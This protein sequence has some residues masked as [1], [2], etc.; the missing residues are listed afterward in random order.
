METHKRIYNKL[1]DKVELASEK[2]ELSIASDIQKAIKALIT[3]EKEMNKAN[4]EILSALKVLEQAKKQSENTYQKYKVGIS[5][6][7]SINPF[8]V[9]R[10]AK[11]AAKELGINANAIKGFDILESDIEFNQDLKKEVETQRDKLQRL[12]K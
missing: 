7:L 4:K 3:Q 11:E 8:T 6:Q 2:I 12:L 1:A 9:I 10:E 5:G